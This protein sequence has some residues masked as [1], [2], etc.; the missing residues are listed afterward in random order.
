MLSHQRVECLAFFKWTEILALEIFDKGDFD[1]LGV[2]DVS[3][4]NWHLVQAN[5]YGC[6]VAPLA[7]HD[8]KTAA[9]LSNDEGLDNALVGNRGHQLREITHYLSGLVWIGV[10]LVDGHLAADRFS[11]RGNSAST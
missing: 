5:L 11:R 6:L 8:L 7:G 10:D 1:Q 2:V 3:N 9:P 4:Y